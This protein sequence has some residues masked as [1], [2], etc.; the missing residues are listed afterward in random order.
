MRSRSKRKLVSRYPKPKSN[1][2]WLFDNGHGGIING[3]YQTPGK[4]SPKWPD[5][6]Q[7]F[8]GEFNRA[9]V[10][11]LI[12][13]C[14]LHGIEYVNLV[15]ELKDISLGERVRRANNLWKKSKRLIYVSIHANAGG[16]TGFEVFTSKGQTKSDKIATYFFNE[17]KDE[18][19]T[20]RAR[21]D[22]TDG[23]AD[24]EANFYVLKKTAMP[25][26]LTESFFMDNMEDCKEILMSEEGRD[27][28]AK[29]HFDAIMAIEKAKP[30]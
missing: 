22:W 3:V 1:Y 5:G 2:V 27:M 18:F 8:E 28:V 19:P 21:P 6:T 26:V 9:I 25:A 29:A 17:F 12:L 23:D 20:E 14:K 11:R 16:G 4:R 15:P 30:I 24:K 10:K 7:L 13:M